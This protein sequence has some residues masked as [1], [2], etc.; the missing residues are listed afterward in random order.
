M[1]LPASLTRLTTFFP[2]LLFGLLR[3]KTGSMWSAAIFHALCNA[4]LL[5]LHQAA[6]VA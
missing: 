3:L 6:G 2:G 1:R 5:G 4:W